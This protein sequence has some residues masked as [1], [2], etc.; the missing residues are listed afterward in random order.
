MRITKF[1]RSEGG[2]L[3]ARVTPDEGGRTIDVHRRYGSWMAGDDPMTQ[4]LTP[5]AKALQEKARAFEKAE[6]KSEAPA[7]ELVMA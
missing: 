7:G 5:V 2:W 4:V 3:T 6:R 1:Q